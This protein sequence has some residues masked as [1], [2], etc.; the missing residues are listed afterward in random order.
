MP[1]RRITEL[2]E[3]TEREKGALLAASVDTIDAAHQL[4]TMYLSRWLGHVTPALTPVEIRH[5]VDVLFQGP[6]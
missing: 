4:G 6:P 5:V 3:L 2:A 1:G